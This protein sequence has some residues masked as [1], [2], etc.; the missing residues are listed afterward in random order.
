MIF[1]QESNQDSYKKIYS[2]YITVLYRYISMLRN[3]IP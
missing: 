2:M 3:V 1:T